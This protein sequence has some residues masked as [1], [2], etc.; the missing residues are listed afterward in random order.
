LVDIAGLR[1]IGIPFSVSNRDSSLRTGH[2]A[3]EDRGRIADFNHGKTR[4]A[5]KGVQE[6]GHR[7]HASAPLG[8]NI[9]L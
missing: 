4:H 9:D 3:E 2:T 5:A 8:Q 6:P 1:K 7:Q